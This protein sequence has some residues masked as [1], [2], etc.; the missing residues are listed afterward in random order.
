MD[1]SEIKICIIGDF[2]LDHYIYGSSNRISPE[3]P[4][5]VIIWE[6]EEIFAG[7]AGNVA[8]NLKSL[9]VQVSCIGNVGDDISG[10][11]LISL[12]N[13][14]GIDTKKIEVIEEYKTTTKRRIF[15]NG[16][17]IARIDEEI[18][19]NSDTKN[20]VGDLSNFDACII[21]DYN[22]GMI[23][24]SNFNSKLIIVD[25]KK[26]SFSNYK[27][28]TIV[29]PNLNE[30]KSATSIQDESEENIIKEC[31]K[32][33]RKYNIKYIIAKK[34]HKGITLVGKNMFEHIESHLVDNPDV[35]GA[36]DTVIAVL[37]A[38]YAKTQD[39]SLAAKVANF[40]ASKVVNKK[41]TATITIN[42]I[43]NY[44]NSHD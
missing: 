2:M 28:A 31:Q 23:S 21:S 22:K 1:F 4:V 14:K 33:I 43:N 26:N 44:I 34:G 3:A 18:F 9:G 30:L 38:V 39:I 40:A 12:L 27:N 24:T 32:L 35:T 20:K 36:G 10:R 42:E 5:P 15:S 17:Q 25:P 16:A 37:S 6:H 7:G 8:I 13:D 41:G 19:F 11:K 29:T